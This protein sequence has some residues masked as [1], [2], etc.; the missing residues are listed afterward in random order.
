MSSKRGDKHQQALWRGLGSNDKSKTV[1]SAAKKEELS[2]EDDEETLG[3]A[4]A[5]QFSSLAA[6]LNHMCLDRS[7]VQYAATRVC[8]KIVEFDAGS[9]EKAQES[10]QTLEMSSRHVGPSV[11]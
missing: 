1:N 9:L 2:Q 4:E 8:T 5:R 10:R 7:G 11:W 6:T 3:A